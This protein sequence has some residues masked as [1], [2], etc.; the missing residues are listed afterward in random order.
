MNDAALYLAL[1]MMISLNLYALMGQAAIQVQ[2]ELGQVL[3][4]GL[5]LAD[6][7]RREDVVVICAE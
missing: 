4:K 5:R 1:I 2:A 6:A 7:Q 3:S